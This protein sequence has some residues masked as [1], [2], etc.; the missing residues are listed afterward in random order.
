[1]SFSNSPI[2][3]GP[4][5]LNAIDVNGTRWRVTKF[6][7]WGTAGTTLSPIQKARQSG[8]AVGDSFATGRTMTIS[9]LITSVSAAQHSLDWDALIAA[10]PR[11]PVLMQVSES[12]RVRW[13]MA[14]R[15]GEIIPQKL[16]AFCSTFTVQVFAT[17]WRKFGTELSA[18][19]LLPSTSGGLL[20]PATVPFTVAATSVSGQVSL[21]NPGNEVGPVW[22]RIDGPTT[23][24]VVTHASSGLMLTFSSSLVLQDGEW[25]DVDMEKHT[26]LANGQVSRSGYVTSR[27][28]SGFVPGD[29][30]WQFTA[31]AFNAASRLTVTAV[32]SWE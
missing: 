10:I 24:P 14:Q 19:T 27:G 26:V 30:T 2:T 11:Y 6:D 21:H 4:L 16:N 1:M 18:S 23:G 9:G 31:A 7:G 8:A 28:W 5:T 25:L 32:P 15:Y 3:F 29:N 22:L 13:C 17:D 12:G 20:V